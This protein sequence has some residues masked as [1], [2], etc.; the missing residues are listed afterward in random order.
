[1]G[2]QSIDDTNNAIELYTNMVYSI[3]YTY[4]K[5]RADADDVYQEVFLALHRNS[6][7]FNDENHRKA[8]LIKTTVNHSKKIALSSWRKKTVPLEQAQDSAVQFKLP[9][10]NLVYTA[11]GELPDKYRMVIFL[12]YFQQQST[13]E[14]SEAL[15]LNPNTV[16]TQLK[17]GREQLYEKLKG[18]Y[19]HE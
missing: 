18:E 9:E 8:W 13:E 3:A 4:L 12:F 11:L 1:M 16:R 5:N 17:R 14:I 2:N 6:K 7:E 10:E 19:F 15:K